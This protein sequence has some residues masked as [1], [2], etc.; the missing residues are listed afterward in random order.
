M[1]VRPT[2]LYPDPRL[3]LAAEPV[4]VFDA[5]LA[6]L[7]QDLLDTMRAAPGVGIA[8]PHIGVLRRLF[9]VQVTPD[10]PVWTCVNP[11]VTSA[12]AETARHLEGSISLPGAAEE[13]E[14]PA[15]VTITYQDLAGAPHEVDAAGLLGVCFQHEIDQLDGIFWLRRLSRLRRDRVLK[16]YSRQH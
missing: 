11:V 7:A 12:S 14:R 15:R 4:S 10:Q 9:V 1:T 13:I 5:E 6:D 2:L 16:R 3:A 8:G